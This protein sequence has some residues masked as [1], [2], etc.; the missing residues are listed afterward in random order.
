MGPWYQSVKVTEPVIDRE[1]HVC[2]QD[3]SLL[4]RSEGNGGSG[5][6]QV[7]VW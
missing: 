5:Q 6:R 4:K 2:I 7:T 1:L 3:E